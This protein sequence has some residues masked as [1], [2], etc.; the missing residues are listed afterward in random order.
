MV[1][2]PANGS[3]LRRALSIL[4]FGFL[5]ASTA[6]GADVLS[7]PRLNKVEAKVLA[8]A[9][10]VTEQGNV[11]VIEFAN[12]FDGNNFSARQ[13]VATQFYQSHADDFDFLVFFTTFD[14]VMPEV[15]VD[16][17]YTRVQDDVQGIGRPALDNTQFYGSHGK[18][19]GLIDMGHVTDDV[20]DPLGPVFQ[21]KLRVLAHEVMHRWCCYID[22][23][24][25]G[26]S[27]ASLRG[28]D[29][30]HWSYFLDSNASVMYGS[31][32]S[33]ITPGQFE[34]EA[35]RKYYSPLDLYLAGFYA[36]Q[37]VPDFFL[38]RNAPGDPTNIPVLFAQVSGA[39]E[40]ISIDQIIG[41][42]GQIRI[43]LASRWRVETEPGNA[44]LSL[45]PPAKRTDSPKS[46]GI[47]TIL[48]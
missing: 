14:I 3:V 13:Q 15:G 9:G 41:N 27:D 28:R 12:N 45:F 32:W 43:S 33:E 17:F 22:Y 38:I 11:T 35:I 36:Q 37:E 5:E 16:G 24:R 34:A 44:S 23:Q 8:S 20:L 18:R 47:F 21:D 19:H 31:D 4:L 25:N 30:A 48:E 39:A 29:G 7:P 40:N 1:I 2:R 46:Q 6:F 42:G 26:V 10:A